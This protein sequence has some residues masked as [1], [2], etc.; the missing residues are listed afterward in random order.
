MAEETL[1]EEVDVTGVD[2]G[3]VGWVL[4]EA[5][6]VVG[7]VEGVLGVHVEVHRGSTQGQVAVDSRIEVALVVAAEGMG[8]GPKVRAVGMGGVRITPKMAQHH[9]VVMDSKMDMEISREVAVAALEMT[10]P[11]KWPTCLIVGVVNS[12]LQDS[13]HFPQEIHLPHPLC[14]II[15]DI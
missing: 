2:Q 15:Q 9:Q 1:V 12:N 5:L 4:G 10:G 7:E 14:N 8:E 13:L 11:T 3:G 6:G